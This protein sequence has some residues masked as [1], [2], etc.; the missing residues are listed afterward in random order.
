MASS[1]LAS[2]EGLIEVHKHSFLQKEFHHQNENMGILIKSYEINFILF[3]ANSIL[4][5]T[6]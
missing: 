1:V 3:N 4:F 6:T 2:Y 5:L